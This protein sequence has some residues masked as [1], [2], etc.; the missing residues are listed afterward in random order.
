MR[1][2][3]RFGLLC[4]AGG[5][6]AFL[7]GPVLA[8]RPT[9]AEVPSSVAT[10]HF[11]VHFQPDPAAAGSATEVIAG[12]VGATAE[13][14]YSA[15][16]ADGY[17]PPMPDAPLGG[18]ARTDIYISD[19]SP[20][21]ALGLSIPDTAGRQSSGYMVLDGTTPDQALNPHTISHELFHLIQF[22]MWSSGGFSDGWLYEGSAEW[23]G[24]R[25]TGYDVS[26]RL[27]LG[28]PEMSLDC[29]DARGLSGCSASDP[30][31]NGG[32]SRWGFFEY[33]SEKL[34]PSFL[35]NVFAQAAD[36]RSSIGGLA[37]ALAAKGTTLAETY[38]AWSTADM[39]G[40]FTTTA[41]QSY[42]PSPFRTVST[43]AKPATILSATVPVDHLATRYLAFEK[44]NS[45]ACVAATLSVTVTIP[46]GALSKPAFFRDAMGS[47]PVQLEVSGSKA[48]ATIPWDTCGSSS[49]LGYLSLPNA[50]QTLDGAAF[51]VTASLALDPAAVARAAVAVSPP[52]ATTPTIN[53]L[54]PELLT[55]SPT[56]PQ[57]HV[58][59]AASGPGLLQARLGSVVLGTR[60]LR[61]GTNDLRITLSKGILSARRHSGTSSNVLTLTPIAAGGAVA[62]PS[63]T[64]TI[65][66]SMPKKGYDKRTK[67][68]A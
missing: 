56:A 45:G 50:S 67:N 1:L 55:I 35:K 36:S 54:G 58:K 17:A 20:F 51:G 10:T 62:G 15:E 53:V 8:A 39:S 59:V 22:G 44:G 27:E 30:Y 29:S 66:V 14:A 34:G 9:P 38:N 68:G 6:A 7:A 21:G 3:N 41:L 5:G 28:P 37:S 63:V 40:G 57:I 61:T 18:D 42:R 13:R 2:L 4:A 46:A 64:R 25:A 47:T 48:S 60:K 26:S 24:Y 43:G 19:L 52:T 16:V 65:S 49:G 23:M 33:L 31:A 32:Y 12:Q 11:V